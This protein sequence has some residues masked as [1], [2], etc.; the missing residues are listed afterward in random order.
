MHK[1]F[2]SLDKKKSVVVEKTRS[3][4]K[5]HDVEIAIDK[6]TELG[7]HIE[8]EAKADFDDHKKAKQHLYKI[9][10]K[11]NAQT[12]KED[13]RGYPFRLLEKS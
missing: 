7:H 11:L 10:E 12:G 5:Y 9:L 2:E 6:V 8:L 3:T 13:L 4:W 1:I